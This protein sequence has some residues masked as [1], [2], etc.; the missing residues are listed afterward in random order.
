MPIWIQFVPFF[1][2]ALFFSS[3][4]FTVFAPVPLLALY[5]KGG[6]RRLSAGILSNSALV[7]GLWSFPGL[8]FYLVYV[9]ALAFALPQFLV[10]RR[11]RPDQAVALTLVSMLSVALALFLSFCF[12]KGVAPLQEA[13]LLIQQGVEAVMEASNASGSKLVPDMPEEELR[14][15]L[16]SEAPSLFAVS[17]LLMTWVSLLML[18][19]LHPI[20]AR[21]EGGLEPGFF[22]NWKAPDSLIWVVIV[23]GAGLVLGQGWIHMVSM[24]LIKFLMVI[25]GLQGVSILTFGLDAL[26][27]R[28]M[29]RTLAYLVFT[30]FMTP[31]LIGLGF[32]DLWF[33]FR[34]KLR[35]S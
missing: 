19:R 4:F 23:G 21:V 16:L 11:G 27:V 7:F 1:L 24:N 26:K 3:F 9:A 33:D 22:R 29:F 12:Y 10:A 31:I 18:F 35:Q 14:T 15:T 13:K 5:L 2:S 32:F 28:G 34:A 30:F 17:A 6:V 20:R 25:Y 8:A